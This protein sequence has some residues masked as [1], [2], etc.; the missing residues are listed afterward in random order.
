MDRGLYIEATNFFELMQQSY[1]IET[2]SGW[3][4]GLKLLL[5][6]LRKPTRVN[7]SGPICS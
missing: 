6:E 7:I 1:P 3:A 2:K 4:Q 5:N